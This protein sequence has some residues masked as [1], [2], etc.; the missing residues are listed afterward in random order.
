MKKIYFKKLRRRK[1]RIT[2]RGLEVTVKIKKGKMKIK[3]K[4]ESIKNN[5]K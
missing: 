2:D 5:L 1:K 3:S 4:L